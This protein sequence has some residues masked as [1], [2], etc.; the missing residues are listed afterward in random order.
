VVV[1][2][3]LTLVDPLAE[4]DVNIPGVIEMLVAPE[5]AQLSTVLAPAEMLPGLAENDEIAGAG[6]GGATVLVNVPQP[7]R[8]AKT[9][10]ARADL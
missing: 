10:V 2:V 1:A 4:V 3:G 5:V 9:K 7:A 6:V 8:P